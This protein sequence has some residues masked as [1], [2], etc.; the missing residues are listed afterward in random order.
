MCE[1]RKTQHWKI[2]RWAGEGESRFVRNFNVG[3]FRRKH[4]YRGW[5]RAIFNLNKLSKYFAIF[6]LGV[7]DIWHFV[8]FFVSYPASDRPNKPTEWRHSWS[9]SEKLFFSFFL[10]L[11][12]Q[13]I[14]WLFLSSSRNTIIFLLNTFSQ[15]S[16]LCL[17]WG[18]MNVIWWNF[19][20]T[21]FCAFFD[22]F[23]WIPRKKSRE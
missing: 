2:Q 21:F 19:L 9:H 8:S 5:K 20:Y 3:G 15:F 23:Y 13:N 1:N 18:W 16:F 17:S 4:Y 7:I 12:F 22:M 10:V 11:H 6:Y 14:S